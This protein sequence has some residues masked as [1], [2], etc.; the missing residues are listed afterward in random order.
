MTGRIGV[1]GVGWWATMNHIPAIVECPESDV[2]ALCDLND[3]RL[4]VAGDAFGIAARHRDFRKMLAEENLDGVIVST[5]HT[6]HVEPAIA[7]LGAGCHA[8]VEKPLATTG[9]DAWRIASAAR[10]ANRQ[11]MVPTGMNFNVFTA[12]AAEWVRSGRIGAVRHATCQMG[13]ALEDLFAGR[14]MLETEGHMFRPP[15]S[16]WADPFKAGGY[17]WGQMPHCIAWLTH[18]ADMKFESV[19]CMDGKS[20]AGVDYYNAACARAVGGATVSLSGSA[21]TPKNRGMH[22]DIRIYG[23]EG[24]ILFENEKPRLSMSRLDGREEVVDLW[25]GEAEYDGA[26]PAKVFARLCAGETLTN[27]SDAECGAKVVELIEAMY[28]SATTGRLIKIGG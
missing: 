10:E 9:A 4:E 5:P 14:P 28:R 21:T 15:A 12:R 3:H 1:V 26:L 16:T 8:M 23:A 27:P 18:V 20:K 19:F 2:V 17:G 7:A 24:M 6:D 13:S 11:V 25:P 22:M